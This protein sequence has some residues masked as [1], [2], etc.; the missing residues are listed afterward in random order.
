MW[1][2]NWG[3]M[4]WGRAS[5]AVPLLG[6]LGLLLLAML[7]ML[8]GA[9]LLRDPAARRRMGKAMALLVL[10]VPLSAFA[11]PFTFT[12]GTVADATQVNQNF[13]SLESRIAALEA[14]RTLAFAHVNANGSIDNDS[15]NITVSRIGAGT[16]CA[17]VSAATPRVAVATLDSLANVGGS[18][19]TGVFAA[20]GCPAG[21]QQLL[22]ITRPH[23]QDGGSPGQDRAFYLVVN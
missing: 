8:S 22:I 23:G 14:K 4:I 18:V 10:L 21:A 9:I 19:Q 12:N 3:T 5:Q 20:S 6:P 1:N 7:L 11:V 17:A 15:G 16:Y 13:T 2:Q